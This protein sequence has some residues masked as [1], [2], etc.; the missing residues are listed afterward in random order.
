MISSRNVPVGHP[1]FHE[2]NTGTP[3][4]APWSSA[5]W[6]KDVFVDQILMAHAISSLENMLHERSSQLI[7][8]CK[9][10]YL[11]R[12]LTAPRGSIGSV[13]TAPSF[14]IS[15]ELLRFQVAPVGVGV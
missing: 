13:N 5:A 1:A 10:V 11:K 15:V 4:V 12:P 9:L 3:R 8:A 14:T 7:S 2:V 6:R